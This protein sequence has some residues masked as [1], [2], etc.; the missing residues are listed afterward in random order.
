MIAVELHKLVR[1]P[2]TWISI[3]LICILPIAVAIFVSVTHLAPPPGQGSAF[4]S[5]SSAGWLA[6][7]GRRA[8]PRPARVPACRRGGR[9]RRLGRG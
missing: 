7:P 3:G 5:A 9:G 4:L 6:V 1:R 2:R 8:R